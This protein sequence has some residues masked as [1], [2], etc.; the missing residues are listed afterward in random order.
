MTKKE[1]GAP[2]LLNA[3]RKKRVAA[4]SGT[5]VQEIN[6]LLKMHRGMGDMMKKMGK[7]G[8]L[9]GLMSGLGGS[10]GGMMGG[11]MPGAGSGMPDLSKMN[12][13]QLE[14]M[15]RQMGGPGSGMPTLP[16][17]GKKK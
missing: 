4:G 9:G 10:L 1:R 8:G 6:K 14:D 11:G 2:K 17:L 15:A 12:P 7:K 3:S 13:K 5:S 16:G